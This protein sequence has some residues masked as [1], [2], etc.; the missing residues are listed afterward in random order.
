MRHP[1]GGGLGMK[2][3]PSAVVDE[4]HRRSEDVLISS[5]SMILSGKE[6]S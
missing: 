3:G 2:I 1:N 6:K 4:S 5:S